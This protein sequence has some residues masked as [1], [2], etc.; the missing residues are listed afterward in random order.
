MKNLMLIAKELREVKSILDLQWKNACQRWA[1]KERELKQRTE[2]WYNGSHLTDKN[3][4]RNRGSIIE[5]I[6]PCPFC[7]GD[8]VMP[9]FSVMDIL[10]GYIPV[11]KCP[12]CLGIGSVVFRQCHDDPVDSHWGE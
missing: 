2:R 11:E 5:T 7:L 4:I 1:E 12:E 3:D 9:M 10:M 8:K 6:S